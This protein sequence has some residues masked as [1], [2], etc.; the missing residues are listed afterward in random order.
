MNGCVRFL[1]GVALLGALASPARATDRDTFNKLIAKVAPSIVPGQPFKPRVACGCPDTSGNQIAGVLSQS[2][3]VVSCLLPSFSAVGT[4]SGAKPLRELRGAR[5]LTRA[6]LVSRHG[7]V[8]GIVA[9]PRDP[10]G[11]CLAL[12]GGRRV[13]RG[14][15]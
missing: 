9:L 7:W 5:S 3:S 11:D 4:F 8:L 13:G 10:A 2:G 1:T 14:T 12:V 15:L 6:R